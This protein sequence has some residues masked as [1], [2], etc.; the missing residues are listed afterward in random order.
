MS[1]SSL[2]GSS[3]SEPARCG[4]ERSLLPLDILTALWA[5]FGAGVLEFLVADHRALP[6]EPTVKVV[7]LLICAT[8]MS[9]A[10]LSLGVFVFLL[11]QPALVPRRLAMQRTL[12]CLAC[13]AV[14]ASYGAPLGWVVA[15]GGAIGVAGCWKNHSP[16]RLR[17]LAITLLL[18]LV[19]RPFFTGHTIQL[20]MSQHQ[21]LSLFAAGAAV[22]ALLSLFFAGSLYSR[23][24]KRTMLLASIAAV[25]ISVVFTNVSTVFLVRLWGFHT[26]LNLQMLVLHLQVA[27]VFV[28]LFFVFRALPQR[29][30]RRASVLSAAGILLVGFPVAQIGMRTHAVK[31]FVLTQPPQTSLILDMIASSVDFDGDHFS[32]LFGYGDCDDHNPDINPLA[33]D[34]PGDGVD[35]NCLAGDL[36]STTHDYFNLPVQVVAPVRDGGRRPRLALLLVVDTLRADAVNYQGGAKHHTPNLALAASRGTIFSRV[37]AQ[38]NNT[39]ESFPTLLQL[40]FR[41]LPYYNSDWTLAQYLREG[42]VASRAVL[43]SSTQEWWHHGEDRVFFGFDQTVRPEGTRRMLSSDAF[44]ARVREALTS[45]PG[46]DL[47]VVA[48]FEELHDAAIEHIAGGRAIDEG[49]DLVEFASMLDVA[50]TVNKLRKRYDEVLSDVDRAFGTIWESLTTLER[51]H[52]LLLVVTAD[53]GE[54]FYEHGGLF[55][56]GTLYDETTRVPLI[57]YRTGSAPK[58]VDSTAT[59]Y[60]VAPTILDFFGFSGAQVEELS[61]LRH[62]EREFEVFSQFALHLR[63]DKRSFMVVE[64]N[65]KLIYE[66]AKGRIEMYDLNSDPGE[67]H[68][69]SIEPAYAQTRRQLLETMETTLFYMAYGDLVALQRR[70]SMTGSSRGS[71]AQQP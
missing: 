47:C 37:Y 38:S 33:I 50:H 54:E 28:P 27:G 46:K 48:V 10:G 55:H 59:L 24:R 67:R 43:Q 36:K 26:M 12:V 15:C 31:R 40:G 44:A 7:A 9:F 1:A 11:Q 61:L 45:A 14:A 57:I 13:A 65:R 29:V 21:V 71:L 69:V 51:T 56:I 20:T 66:P 2:S 58:Q 30:L 5:G 18:V 16:I 25:L 53:H 49:L 34:W 42:G 23:S 52:D 3:G 6:A 62:P 35:Q 68:D 22:L 70:A 19:L 32:P 8:Q 64:N 41:K 60:R 39:M 63:D 17:T 4:D